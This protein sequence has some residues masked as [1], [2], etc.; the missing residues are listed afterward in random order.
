MVKINIDPP[1]FLPYRGYHFLAGNY[2]V[3]FRIFRDRAY[4]VGKCGQK[5]SIF[6][7]LDDFDGPKK[8]LAVDQI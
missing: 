4:I 1:K 2:G 8:K 7:I 3:I 6:A 5:R